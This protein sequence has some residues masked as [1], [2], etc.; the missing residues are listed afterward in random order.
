MLNS[1]RNGL[2]VPFGFFIAVAAANLLFMDWPVG[3]VSAAEKQVYVGAGD[4]RILPYDFTPMYFLPA[5]GESRSTE[6]YPV[7]QALFNNQFGEAAEGKFVMP[8]L[9]GLT[10]P[11]SRPRVSLD[12]RRDE[13]KTLVNSFA[14]AALKVSDHTTKMQAALANYLRIFGQAKQESGTS[15]KESPDLSM[16]V[17]DSKILQDSFGALATVRAL[18]AAIGMKNP[19]ASSMEDQR[20]EQSIVLARKHALALKQSLERLAARTESVLKTPAGELNPE[21]AEALKKA[22]AAIECL[23]DGFKACDETLA[24][25]DTQFQESVFTARKVV[26]PMA[27]AINGVNQEPLIGEIRLFACNYSP[28]EW[29]PCDG[30]ALPVSRYQALSALL[31]DQFGGDG[32]KTIALPKMTGPDA[33]SK[34][35]LQYHMA[36]GGMYPRSGDQGVGI[37]KAASGYGNVML[38]EVRLMPY[39]TAPRGWLPCDGRAMPV[40]K[41]QALFALLGKAFGGDGKKTFKLPN[42]KPVKTGAGELRYYIV[43]QGAWPSR[44]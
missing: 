27:I 11:K 21:Q 22:R 23:Q 40:A 29:V 33:K 26:I 3:Q 20:I 38:S 19:D 10:S 16:I 12:Q 8:K 17:S 15:E 28:R 1:R 39:A 31:K 6:D 4:A 30:R 25:L 41:Y 9:T 7:L 44:N 18:D 13:A 42:L 5:D 34:S 14:S 32:K 24:S 35:H 43:V 2:A 36:V 37:E